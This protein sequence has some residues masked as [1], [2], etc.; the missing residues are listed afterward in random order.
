MTSLPTVRFLDPVSKISMLTVQILMILTCKKSTA[1][2]ALAV[3]MPRVVTM[4]NLTRCSSTKSYA[5][6][7]QWGKDK[8]FTIKMKDKGYR[9]DGLL[10]NNTRLTTSSEKLTDPM[11]LPPTYHLGVSIS[12]WWNIGF[13]YGGKACKEPIVQAHCFW[14]FENEDAHGTPRKKKK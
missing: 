12:I 3:M 4:S 13:G 11:K 9:D 10:D 5:L 8:R 2:S 14:L 1:P 7:D 6:L